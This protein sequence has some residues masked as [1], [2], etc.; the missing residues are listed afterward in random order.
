MKKLEMNQVECIQGGGSCQ[1][2]K[3]WLF[4]NNMA[5]LSA[6]L[7]MEAQGYTFSC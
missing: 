7:R 2:I 6:I 1:A 4:L 3:D 5:Q